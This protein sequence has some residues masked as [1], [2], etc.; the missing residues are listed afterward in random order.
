MT[1]MQAIDHFHDEATA[2]DPYEYYDYLLRN[3][4]VFVEPKHGVAI[5]TGYEEALAVFS[6]P[7]TFSSCNLVAGPT[8]DLPE[9][10]GADDITEIMEQYR[11]ELPQSDQIVT[12]D[13]PKHTD[14]RALLMGLITPKRLK[15]NEDFVWR[16]TDRQLDAVLPLGKCEL[17]NDYAQPYTLL[18]IA[19]LLGVPESDHEMLLS[20]T[21]LGGEQMLGGTDHATGGAAAHNSLAPLYDYFMEQIG[22]RRQQP[23]GDVLTGMASGT[24]PDGTVPE[25]VD[26]ARIASNM[27]AAGQETT[28]RLLGTAL[29]LIGDDPDLQ[30]RLRENRELI[31]RF[32]EET[33]RTQGPIKG[34]FRLVRK[35]TTLGGVDL[36]AGTVV[37]L[38]HAAASRDPRQ[39]ECPA[40]LRLDRA[41]SR[42]HVAFG[43]GVHTCPGAPLARSEVRI[44]IERIFDRT[45][46]IAISEEHHGPAGARHY[47]YMP[48]Y[49][50]HGLMNLHLEFSTEE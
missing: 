41:N 3:S 38:V 17:I 24:F 22:K 9:F 7:A 4:P 28:V 46:D 32:L 23:L 36:K 47:E 30:R 44:T 20:R 33:L 11:D 35:S 12:F 49:M 43:H 2:Q 39:F 34:A 18:V 27:F 10:S 25:L 14:H 16:L 13:P 48:T 31:P 8:P 40:E 45:T 15:E 42:R 37:L 29:Q 50:F 5:V 21:G 26:V 1:D 6:D 19:D